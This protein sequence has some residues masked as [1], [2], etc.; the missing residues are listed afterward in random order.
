M[1]RTICR[2]LIL[3]AA[4][5]L[6]LGCAGPK[7]DT[8]APA[9]STAQ[10]ASQQKIYIDPTS[11]ERTTP[12]KVQPAEQGAKRTV[13]AV[14]DSSSLE[15]E[16]SPVQ[17]GGEFIRLQGRFQTELNATVDGGEVHIE[18]RTVH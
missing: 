5:P 1:K 14:H 8:L 17:G 12:P 18:E 16:T 4:L 15:V 7:Q 9:A 3:M 13:E 10:A 6:L 2:P 11:G